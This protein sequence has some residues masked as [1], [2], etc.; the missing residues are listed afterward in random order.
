MN[1][2]PKVKSEKVLI[3]RLLNRKMPNDNKTALDLLR[4][5]STKS[6]VPVDFLAANAIQEGL[7]E[8]IQNQA[9]DESAGSQYPVSGFGYYG[10]DT[11]GDAAPKLKKK[12]YIP[13]DMDYRTYTVDNEKGEV[14]TPANFK[15]NEDAMMAKAA[16]LKDFTDEVRAYS[17]KKGVKMEPKTEQYLTMAAYNGGMGNAR[18]MIDEL[19]TGK[20]SQKDYIEK[21]LTSRKGVHKNIAPRMEKM[22]WILQMATGPAPGPKQQQFPTLFDYR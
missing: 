16:Y 11:F 12:G 6:K 1:D 4:R 10:L 14:V 21:G 22:N 15:S 7:L 5:V 19:S 9:Y 17:S 13:Q 2:K 20:F 8:A 3:N 18:K